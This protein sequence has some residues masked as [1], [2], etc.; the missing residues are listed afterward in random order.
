MKLK[1]LINRESLYRDVPSWIWEENADIES[2][3]RSFTK[4]GWAWAK[5]FGEE[6]AEIFRRALR[7][8]VNNQR[9]YLFQVEAPQ[10]AIGVRTPIALNLETPEDF[11]K[12]A[13]TPINSTL[14]LHQ[15]IK[16]PANVAKLNYK[17]S[18][19]T[20]R[21]SLLEPPKEEK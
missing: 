5:Y 17:R 7:V 6:D 10:Q 19:P 14:N 11:E 4:A 16:D 9:H 2:Y 15:P 20:S 3:D 8:I 18:N 13:Q 21:R 1:D 12:P